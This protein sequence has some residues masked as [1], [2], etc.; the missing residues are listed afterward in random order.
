MPYYKSEIRSSPHLI[1]T[2][3]YS[4]KLHLC[5][6]TNSNH[7][8][9]IPT[10]QLALPSSIQLV[11][12]KRHWQAASSSLPSSL[13]LCCNQLS[14]CRSI[15]PFIPTIF[16]TLDKYGGEY[17]RQVLHSTIVH[18]K[19]L[20]HR[21]Y[22]CKYCGICCAD[23]VALEHRTLLLN[24]RRNFNTRENVLLQHCLQFSSILLLR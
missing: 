1:G 18:Y 7:Y 6:M 23:W 11:Q 24:P 16:T 12:G 20:S 14:R 22:Y 10:K 5:E 4:I 2:F 9:S 13:L 15:F 17:E 8:A 21:N 19:L 3:M